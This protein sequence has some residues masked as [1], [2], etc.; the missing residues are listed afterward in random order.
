V[1]A[2]CIIHSFFA[3]GEATLHPHS[4]AGSK[5]LRHGEA[6]RLDSGAGFGGYASDLGRSLGVGKVPEVVRD[7]YKRLRAIEREIIGS[8][9]AGRT[10][11]EI[12]EFGR[13]AFE[14]HQLSFGLS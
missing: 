2:D 11:A 8:L 7:T 12:F 6:G 5:P 3:T 1:G 9:R 14:G 10:A 4:I 13:V